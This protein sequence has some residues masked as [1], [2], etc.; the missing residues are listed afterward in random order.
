MVPQHLLVAFMFIVIGESLN[1]QCGYKLYANSDV[2]NPTTGT[3]SWSKLVKNYLILVKSWSKL[4]KN[5]SKLVKIG[6]K[7]VKIGQK[8]LSIF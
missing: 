6:Q 8:N 3:L 7:L 1:F 4:V 2:S 5:W